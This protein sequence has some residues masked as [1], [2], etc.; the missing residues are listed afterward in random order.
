MK[1]C[2]YCGKAFVPVKYV[3]N[4]Q[5]FCS[6]PCQRQWD[7]EHRDRR[8]EAV[9]ICQHCGKR[10]HPKAKD[11]TTYCSRECAFA[12]KKAKAKK[13]EDK[14][15][16]RV[17]KIEPMACIQCG[18]EF[19][20]HYGATLC[21]E[22]CAKARNRQAFRKHKESIG[23]QAGRKVT[24]SCEQC[25]KQFTQIVHN[26]IKK[27]C[28]KKCSRQAWRQ[29]NPEKAALMRRQENHIRRAR[30]VSTEHESIR[31]GDVF[32]RDG[33]RCG[34]CG[35]KVD[36]R[37]KFPHPKSVTLDHIIPLAKGGTHTWDNVQCA[38]FMCNCLKGAHDGGQLRL[39]LRLT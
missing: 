30:R 36:K 33:W 32:E 24:I 11:R 19:M 34:I 14:N 23:R 21:S 28:S 17:C 37:L 20:A 6:E 10:F 22:E 26:R 13:P 39:E 9:Y 3:G 12:D 2:E 27:Y 1:T 8:I 16:G 4:R 38:H 18:K 35:K 31:V 5:R 7:A 29:A 15:I 25:G